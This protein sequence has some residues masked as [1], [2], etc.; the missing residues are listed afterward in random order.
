LL[1]QLLVPV[2]VL[3]VVAVVLVL[4]LALLSVSRKK[5]SAGYC[6]PA[7]HLPVQVVLPV[8]VRSIYR[9]SLYNCYERSAV[10]VQHQ[11]TIDHQTLRTSNKKHLKVAMDIP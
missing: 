4:V 11:R 5:D 3:P 2:H 10:C 9:W 1:L 7:L 8:G 6:A